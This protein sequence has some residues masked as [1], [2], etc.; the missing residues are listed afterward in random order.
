MP[1]RPC[2]FFTCFQP[3][4]TVFPF[5]VQESKLDHQLC[6]N[7]NILHVFIKR[8]MFTCIYCPEPFILFVPLFLCFI[9]AYVKLVLVFHVP[10]V[11]DLNFWCEY[12]SFCFRFH[13][14]YCTDTCNIEWNNFYINDCLCVCVEL[15]LIN[16]T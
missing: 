11:F 2:P 10:L 4:S 9:H 6:I 7:I 1:W 15:L 13:Q 8:K 12:G 5:C 14:A 16:M 3:R